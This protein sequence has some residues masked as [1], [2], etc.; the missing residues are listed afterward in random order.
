MRPIDCF[1]TAIKVTHYDFLEHVDI[2]FPLEKLVRAY[3]IEES[4]S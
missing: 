1:F 2:D 4:C 3:G